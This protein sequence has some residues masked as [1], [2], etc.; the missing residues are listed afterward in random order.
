M[1]LQTLNREYE[2]LHLRDQNAIV[3]YF[4]RLMTLTSKMLTNGETIIDQMKVNNVLRT[5]TH[6]FDHVVV[7]LEGSKS[8]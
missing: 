6:K 2:L 8:L 3:E 5:L 7:A 4:M 1:K